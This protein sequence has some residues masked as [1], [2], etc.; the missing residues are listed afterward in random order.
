[1]IID[2]AKGVPPASRRRRPGDE[3]PSRRTAAL[4]AVT[5]RATRTVNRARRT[6]VRLAD[7]IR[8]GRP[9]AVAQ[10]APLVDALAAE[11][12]N[13]AAAILGVLRLKSRDQYTYLHSVAVSALMMNLARTMGADPARLPEI[14]MA[15]LLHDAGKID[16]PDTI[17]NKPG[18]L[19]DREFAIMRSHPSRGH[20]LLLAGIGVPKLALDVCLHHHERPDGRGYPEGLSGERLSLAARMGAIC[21]VYDALTSDRAYK[22]A[23]S[24]QRALAEMQRW[25]GQFDPAVLSAFL[26]SLGIFP[27]GSLVKVRDSA[28]AVVL[29]DNDEEPTCPTVRAFYSVAV[30]RRVA[31][32]D[33]PIKISG[34]LTLE[35]PADWGFDDWPSLAAKLLDG[36]RGDQPARSSGGAKR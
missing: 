2:S 36:D 11:V 27:V 25:D 22:N 7:D 16:I 31:G 17:L 12:E 34:I 15:G 20:S 5:M 24:P 8:M 13:N 28:L 29:A 6:M 21:D 9:I 18:P 30:R 19:T 10:L 1:V 3:P 14:G 23:W 26:R 35:D 32:E 33:I 4:D